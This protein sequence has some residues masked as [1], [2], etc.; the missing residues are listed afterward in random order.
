[1]NRIRACIVE[2]ELLAQKRLMRLLEAHTETVEIIGTASNAQEAVSMIDQ[3]CPDLLFLD[4]Q[5]TGTT[6]FDVLGRLT[7]RPRVIFTTAFAEHAIRAFEENALDYLLKPIEPERLAAA[8]DRVEVK[9]E[10]GPG[11][12]QDQLAL[13]ASKLNPTPQVVSIP[14]KVGERFIFISLDTITHFHAKEKY[15]YVHTQDGKEYLTDHTLVSLSQKLPDHFM[16]VHRAYIVNRHAIREVLNYF[17][18]K[19]ILHIGDPVRV[20]ITTGPS[21]AEKIKEVLSF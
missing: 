2:D 20:K 8:I 6:G 19:Y 7:H 17:N 21:Y 1:M 10:S 14:V 16:Q 15:V 13:L 9:E 4:I 11:L 5:L 18:N 3:L 12:S